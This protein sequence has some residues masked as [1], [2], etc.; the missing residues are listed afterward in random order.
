MPRV[1]EF[2][3]INIEFKYN[4]HNPPHCHI[5]QGADKL[6]TILL[7]EIELEHS[8]LTKKQEKLIV[9]WAQLYQEE[10]L[11]NWNL[12]KEKKQLKKIPPLSKEIL[13]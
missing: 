6:G 10:L 13:L 5:M 12:A 2:L 1:S 7:N 11:E 8:K 9:G 4:E 3:G